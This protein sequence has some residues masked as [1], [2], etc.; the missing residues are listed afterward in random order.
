MRIKRRISA[1]ALAFILACGILPRQAFAS[2]GGF[3]P[4][5]TYEGQFS[6]IPSDSWFYDTVKALYELGLTNGSGSPDRFDPGGDLTV[7][8]V[9]TMVSRLRSLYETGSS[10][11][12]WAA[13]GGGGEWYAPYAA[14][15]QALEIIGQ[16]FE[17]SYDR[18]ATRAEMAHVLAGALPGEQLA[19]INQEAVASGYGRGLYI[20]DVTE[21][22]PYRDD[23]LQLYEW[24][25]AGGS[26]STGS[27]HPGSRIARSEAAAMVARLAYSELRLTLDW[28]VL[29]LYSK[30]GC[31]LEALVES[32]GTF[33]SSPDLNS[34][35]QI[36]ADV[37]YMLANGERTITLSYPN[38]TISK[39][40]ADQ[41]MNAFLYAVRDY[42]EQTYNGI[43][44]IYYPYPKGR[45]VTLTFS[46]SLYDESQ[47]ARYREE[48][49][50]FAIA[51]H[52]QMW[53]EGRITA[54]MP[55]YEKARAYFTWICENCRYDHSLQDMSHTAYRLFNEGIAVCDGYTAAYNLL[56]KLEGI[57]CG[58]CTVGDHI[59]TEAVLDGRPYHIDTT[60]GD[61]ERGVAYRYFAM[62]EQDSLARF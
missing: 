39:Q 62:T 12:G 61:Q 53:A 16:E 47:I 43:S 11:S 2:E 10:E 55:E 26:D 8:E 35:E 59:W 9:V 18:P 28:E 36:D 58:T 13:Y 51:V 41:L 17:G 3:T 52:D 15:L 49:M 30:K 24:G 48:T 45:E 22:T 19:P 31:T 29:P 40:F 14:H 46:S 20:R 33:Y 1:M 60:W 6:D 23:I 21:D 32:D 38:E 57:S 5:R 56:L 44:A 37:R 42:V 25:V 4:I 50:N 34:H 54:E 27:F 7:A